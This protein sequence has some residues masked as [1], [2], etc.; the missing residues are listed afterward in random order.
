MEWIDDEECEIN[1]EHFSTPK[2]PTDFLK[3]PNGFPV[4]L[5][6]FTLCNMNIK[7]QIFGGSDFEPIEN[8]PKKKQFAITDCATYTKST[9]GRVL[10]KEREIKRSKHSGYSRCRDTLVELC[11]KKVSVLI[12]CL[13][14]F[15]SFVLDS[16]SIRYLSGTYVP[17]VQ[18]LISSQRGRSFR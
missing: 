16:I 6:K 11:L 1:E 12:F 2:G 17:S 9:E 10:I 14:F 7:F 5:K 3:A 18:A 4:P 13:S 8:R 15:Y